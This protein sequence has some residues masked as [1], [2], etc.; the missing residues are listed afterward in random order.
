MKKTL[1]LCSLFILLP[2]CA[3]WDGIWN[4]SPVNNDKYSQLS[5]QAENEI[6]LADKAGFLWT[7]TVNLMKESKDAKSAADKAAKDGDN[8]RAKSEFDMAMKFAKKALKEAQLAQQQA[9]DNA[10]P[11]ISYK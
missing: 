9:A 2:G 8:T 5:T 1:V 11:V 6:K 4:D 10:N 3:W 7:D